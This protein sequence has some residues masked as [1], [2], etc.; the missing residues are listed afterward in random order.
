MH[1]LTPADFLALGL[2]L[3]AVTEKPHTLPEGSTCAITGQA[4]RIGYQVSDMVTPATAEFLDCFK[5]GIHG[6]ISENAARCYRS[7]DPKKGNLCAKAHCAVLLPDS[8]IHYHSPAFDPKTALKNNTMS[9]AQTFRWLEQHKGQQ[10]FL[11]MTPDFKKRKWPYARAGILGAQTPV[12]LDYMDYGLSGQFFMDFD[13]LLGLL[14]LVEETY[15]KGFSKKAIIQTLYQTKSTIEK[16]GLPET[17]RLEA[18]LA[19]HRN[20]LELTLAAMAATK[21][22]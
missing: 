16:V 1:T 18:L 20:R 6:H 5:G 13:V 7:A 21:E 4:I 9:W 14:P 2:K 15:R 22:T 12:F 19:P 17:Q 11:L 8:Q 3:P 10:V